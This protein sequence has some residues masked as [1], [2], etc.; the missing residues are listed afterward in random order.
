MPWS[1]KAEN[2]ACFITFKIEFPD[3][4]LFSDL[5]LA[6]RALLC[7]ARTARNLPYCAIICNAEQ[8]GV[9]YLLWGILKE[10][11]I[12]LTCSKEKHSVFYAFIVMAFL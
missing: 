12:V 7:V 3:G 4:W 1:G 9:L 8:F 6:V 11:T 2:K 10:G 5:L